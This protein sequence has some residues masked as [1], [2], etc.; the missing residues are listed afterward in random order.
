MPVSVLTSVDLPAPFS[1]TSASTWRGRNDSVTWSSATMPS[2]RL[3]MP[4]SVS[5]GA[6][7][8]DGSAAAPEGGV[9]FIGAGSEDFGELVDIVLVVGERR[10]HRRLAVGIEPQLAHAADGHALARLAAGA[11]LDEFIG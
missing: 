2:K 4:A 9:M 5:T 3:Q 8:T 7:Q 10:R 11:A 1:P 6:G